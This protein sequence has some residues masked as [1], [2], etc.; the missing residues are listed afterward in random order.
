MTIQWKFYGRQKEIRELNDFVENHPRFDLIAI[1]GRR[2]VGKSDLIRTFFERQTDRRAIL[3]KLEDTDTSH[4]AFFDRLAIATKKID[5]HLLADFT[6]DE[7]EQNNR[8]STLTEHLLQQKCVVI[9]DEFQNI[10]NTGNRNMQSQFQHLID[11]LRHRNRNPSAPYCRL[12]L[13][14]SEQQRFWEMLSH[15]RAPMYQRV[16]KSIHVQPWTF[17]E[18]KEMALD[19]GWNRCPNRL[20]TLWTAYNGLPRHWERFHEDTPRLSD[21]SQIPDDGE[22]TRQFMECEEAHRQ[23]RDGAFHRQ[24][25]IELRESDRA[26]VRWLAE[27]PEGRN[28]ATDLKAPAER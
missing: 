3:C 12:I 19:Q 21:F 13:L 16:R 18:F 14:G 28:L 6:V 25:E 24:M 17:P 15:P 11:D 10:G 2:Q 9:L 27:K 20:L 26:I 23:T 4:D 1:R 8:F 5:P 22:W 7:Y